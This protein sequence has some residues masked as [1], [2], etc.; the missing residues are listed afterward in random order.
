MY[1]LTFDLSLL[2]RKKELEKKHDKKTVWY[3]NGEVIME[4]FVVTT[5]N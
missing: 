5:M 4:I 2:F 1:I 3:F